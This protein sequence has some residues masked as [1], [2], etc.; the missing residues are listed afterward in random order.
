MWLQVVGRECT[1]CFVGLWF[2]ILKKLTKKIRFSDHKTPYTLTLY[3]GIYKFQSIQL[4]GSSCS[5]SQAG[6]QLPREQ[7]PFL[8][9]PPFPQNY[10]FWKTDVGR[11]FC[12][13]FAQFLCLEGRLKGLGVFPQL[14]GVGK[15]QP[16]YKDFGGFFGFNFWSLRECNVSSF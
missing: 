10:R 5:V 2:F 1:G 15:R 14:I 11:D 4:L 3:N 7:Y 8:P 9:I 16:I 13:V 6:I 12:Q